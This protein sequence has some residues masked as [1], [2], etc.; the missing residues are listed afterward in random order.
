MNSDATVGSTRAA[1][2]GLSIA[3]VFSLLI[4]VFELTQGIALFAVLLGLYLGLTAW[5]PWARLGLTLTTLAM[6]GAGAGLIGLGGL[7]LADP[8][9]LARRPEHVLPLLVVILAAPV[10]LWIDARLHREAWRKWGRAMRQASLGAL[11][12]GQHL[13]SVE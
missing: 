7:M 6:G 1:L 11:L 3:A 5:I 9:V 10:L 12:T 2:Y 13:R 8:A 4:F